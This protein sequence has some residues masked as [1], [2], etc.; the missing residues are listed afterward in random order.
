MC[1]HQL[2]WII[3]CYTESLQNLHFKNETLYRQSDFPKKNGTWCHARES[4]FLIDEFIVSHVQLFAFKVVRISANL[5]LWHILSFLT[6]CISTLYPLV[7]LT[8]TN[9]L[10]LFKLKHSLCFFLIHVSL[11]INP[12]TWRIQ[13]F[14]IS[15]LKSLFLHVSNLVPHC[16]II[17][18]FPHPIKSGACLPVTMSMNRKSHFKLLLNDLDISST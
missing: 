1:K 3:T 9:V 10:F 8:N 12:N 7:T 16:V 15:T 18:Y 17:L 6:I 4:W 11:R 13:F 14:G 5:G 2:S